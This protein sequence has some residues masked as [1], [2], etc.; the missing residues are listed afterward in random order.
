MN[1]TGTPLPGNRSVTAPVSEELAAVL[2]RLRRRI[3]LYVAVEGTAL[4]LVLLAVL[5]WASLGIDWAWFRINRLEL[6]VW[7]R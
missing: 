4:L 7:F 6:P 1:S 2:T 3:R 5:F